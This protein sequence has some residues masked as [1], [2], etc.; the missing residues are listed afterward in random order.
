MTLYFQIVEG[1]AGVQTGKAIADY[2]DRPRAVA[3]CYAMNLK[4]GKTQ[5]TVIEHNANAHPSFRVKAAGP[6]V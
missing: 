6:D 2:V 1:A 5:Y 4:S 3:A